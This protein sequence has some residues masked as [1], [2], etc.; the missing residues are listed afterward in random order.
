MLCPFPKQPGL[1]GPNITN[2]PP[3]RVLDF[4]SLEPV[5]NAIPMDPK[6]PTT[7]RGVDKGNGAN[8]GHKGAWQ[9]RDMLPFDGTAVDV[10]DRIER[11]CAT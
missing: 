6:R 2:A 11:F 7:L 3:A 8:A 10:R 5:R 1:S 9:V 4:N